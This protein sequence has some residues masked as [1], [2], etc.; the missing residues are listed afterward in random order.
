VSAD[1]SATRILQ[2]GKILHGPGYLQER[3]TPRSSASRAVSVVPSE[4]ED[5]DRQRLAL[6]CK[7]VGMIGRKS[8]IP[9][10]AAAG[11]A[12]L[13]QEAGELL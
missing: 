2:A 12:R 5:G 10:E 7:G 8:A 6:P 9:L 3:F 1:M 13:R 11:V 4:G